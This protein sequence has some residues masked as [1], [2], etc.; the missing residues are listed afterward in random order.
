VNPNPNDGTWLKKAVCV[1]CP[2]G[3]EST[4][5]KACVPCAA[6]YI[7]KPLTGGRKRNTASAQCDAC[8]IGSDREAT[9]GPGGVGGAGGNM[10]GNAGGNG[11]ANGNANNNARSLSLFQEAARS[12]Q[13]VASGV[14]N[15]GANGGAG[16]AAAGAA[17]DSCEKCVAG[18]YTPSAGATC[19]ACA[20]NMF[21]TDSRHACI[22]CPAGQYRTVTDTVNEKCLDCG[23]NEYSKLGAGCHPCTGGFSAVGFSTAPTVT[24]S[25]GAEGVS[26]GAQSNLKPLICSDMV[27]NS[28]SDGS[29]CCGKRSSMY[30]CISVFHF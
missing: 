13:G 1:D 5:G 29:H 17:I 30:N 22:E 21:S 20:A 14:G 23:V 27:R 8:P 15:G 16:G 24:V 28:Y 3:E 11:N 26:E 6:N 4:D 7:K 25:A 9:A 19:T 18:S 2:A 10:G 12:L